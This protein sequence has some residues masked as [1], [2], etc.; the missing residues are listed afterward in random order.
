MFRSEAGSPMVRSAEARLAGHEVN[1]SIATLRRF[2]VPPPGHL[3]LKYRPCRTAW[4]RT[5][6]KAALGMICGAARRSSR[7]AGVHARDLVVD[8]HGWS[9]RPS[10]PRRAASHQRIARVPGDGRPLASECDV[11]VSVNRNPRSHKREFP[12]L[13]YSGPLHRDS[14]RLIAD[15]I[16]HINR[17]AV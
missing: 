8:P 5:H 3:H 4:P 7:A 6:R 11:T 13:S 17:R 14:G 12:P 16:R 10:P 9:L 2:S 1:A 15:C